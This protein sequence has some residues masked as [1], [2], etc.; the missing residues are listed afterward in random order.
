MRDKLQRRQSDSGYGWLLA[1]W[2]LV[3][4]L[5]GWF[6]GGIVAYVHFEDHVTNIQNRMDFHF[7]KEW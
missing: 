5:L 6:V 7:G 4:V 1:N 3:V 2:P